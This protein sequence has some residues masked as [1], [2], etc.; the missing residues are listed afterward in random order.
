MKK[1]L[2]GSKAGDFRLY[3]TGDGTA[4]AARRRAHAARAAAVHGGPRGRPERHLRRE[5]VEA[6]EDWAK[7]ARP[8]RSRCSSPASAIGAI[9]AVTRNR[10]AIAVVVAAALCA[11]SPRC[12]TTAPRRPER[13]G[14]GPA[15][16]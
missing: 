6:I 4:R 12:R 11:V 15:A 3:A 10:V 16:G 9:M 8:A 1:A 14:R 7:R 5:A 13:Q 2:A